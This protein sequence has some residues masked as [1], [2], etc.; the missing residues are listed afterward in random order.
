MNQHDP[1]DIATIP[2]KSR[3]DSELILTIAGESDGEWMR[4]EGPQLTR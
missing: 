3:V 2:E 1:D 4:Y